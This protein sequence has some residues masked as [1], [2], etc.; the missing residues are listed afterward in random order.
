MTH[1]PYLDWLLA[2]SRRPEETLAADQKAALQGHLDDCPECRRLAAAWQAVD[3]ELRAA[4]V[5]EPAPGFT[6]RWQTRLDVDRQSQRR[7]QSMTMFAVSLGLALVLFVVLLVLAWP[8]IQSPRLLLWTYIFQVIRWASLFAAVQQ[9]TASLLRGA[10]AALSP[11]GTI[12]A[13]GGLSLMAVL[14]V[15]SYRVL[16][17]PERILLRRE[18]K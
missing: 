12:F 4:L 16:T 6:A 1:Q 18:I 9:F 11:L 3:G 15:V 14:W 17:N 13:V 10:V 7:R 5:L 2:D 8:V